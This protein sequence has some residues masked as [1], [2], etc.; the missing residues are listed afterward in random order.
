LTVSALVISYKAS[1][2]R[3]VDTSP[4]IL[5]FVALASSGNCDQDDRGPRGPLGIKRRVFV[6]ISINIWKFHQK[7]AALFPHVST[8]NLSSR[9]ELRDL[10][11]FCRISYDNFQD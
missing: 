4:G 8:N 11:V 2:R 5:I 3:S 1:E 10:Q 9:C 7:L 6:V